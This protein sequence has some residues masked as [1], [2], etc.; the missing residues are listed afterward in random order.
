M[1]KQ[2][3]DDPRRVES[4]A[5]MTVA[6]AVPTPQE[7]V[8]RVADGVAAVSITHLGDGYSGPPLGYEVRPPPTLVAS[9]II[10][11]PQVTDLSQDPARPWHPITEAPRD[12]TLVEG[13]AA[14]GAEFHMIW[15][16][17]SRFDARLSKWVPVGFWSSHLSREPLKVEPVQFRLPEGF[18]TPGMVCA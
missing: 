2:P 6:E 13:R 5:R 15:R 12:G 18:V 14:D 1:S 11:T 16:R 7:P 4:P 10:P 3:R 9:P 17:T 8:M